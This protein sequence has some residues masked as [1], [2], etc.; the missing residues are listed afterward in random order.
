MACIMLLVAFSGFSVNATEYKT[1][2]VKGGDV[3]PLDIIGV[4]VYAFLDN[5]NT[6]I[7]GVLVIER[8]K[9][10]LWGRLHIPIIHIGS[11][12]SNGEWKDPG[13]PPS[14]SHIG[15]FKPGYKISSQ[16]K[17]FTEYAVIVTF[18]LTPR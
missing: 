4:D 15:V 13:A 8:Y 14:S 7:K 18:Y 12:D 3:H 1:P 11:T 10:T 16:E 9:S 17:D 6:P 2:E 5:T